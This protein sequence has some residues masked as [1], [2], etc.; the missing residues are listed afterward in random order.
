MNPAFVNALC[1][2]V[3][4]ALGVLGFACLIAR[5]TTEQREEIER[6]RTLVGDNT[7]RL[8]DHRRQG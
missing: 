4:A 2:F 1:F 6:L 7:I 5:A 8:D 3:G